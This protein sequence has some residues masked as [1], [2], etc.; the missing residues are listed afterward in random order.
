M[1]AHLLALCWP[2][3]TLGCAEDGA[4]RVATGAA[5]A[6]GDANALPAD[7]WTS[8]SSS[9][10]A[11]AVELVKRVVVGREASFTSVVGKLYEA[12]Q[13]D[14]LTWEVLQSGAS[15]C[16]LSRPVV[17]FCSE[18]CAA[19]SACAGTGECVPYPAARDIGVVQAHGL[20]DSD[21]KLR[22][23]G[24]AY[25]VPAEVQL[26]NPPCVEDDSFEL[27]AAKLTLVGHCIASLAVQTA[28]PVQVVLDAPLSLSW[29]PALSVARS[30][31]V[32]TL[33]V[34]HHGGLKG[35]LEC[36]HADD[37]QLQISRELLRALIDL[38]TAGF[39]ALTMRRV[40][41]TSA[42]LDGGP[43]A[44]EVS[45]AVTLSLKLPGVTSCTRS[46]DCAAGQTCAADLTC[47]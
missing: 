3:L 42:Q 46:Q 12:P 28:E 5:G 13:P 32:V 4:G 24:G 19:G 20:G 35:K 34:S 44:L 33:D 23:V 8:E 38:G 30:H 15:G 40:S 47:R 7:E 14:V 45:S 9:V 26:D 16:V 27:S 10:G 21:F 6:G 11:F 29:Q 37:G 22:F 41:R 43:V 17:P 2:I 18:G 39:P 1:K 25:Q 36:T 31:V